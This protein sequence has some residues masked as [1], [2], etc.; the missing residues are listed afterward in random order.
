MTLNSNECSTHL[1]C[2]NLKRKVCTKVLMMAMA[3]VT[4]AVMTSHLSSHEDGD[5]NS[6]NN[7]G[8]DLPSVEN[9]VRK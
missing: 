2:Y 8:W 7:K 9:L 3:I 5:L 4:I 1:I 6:L